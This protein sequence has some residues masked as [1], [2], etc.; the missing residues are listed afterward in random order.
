MRRL[1]LAINKLVKTKEAY[2]DANNALE[3]MLEGLPGVTSVSIYSPN[4]FM[5][6]TEFHS[7]DLYVHSA[8]SGDY[9]IKRVCDINLPEDVT[10]EQVMEMME[11]AK[12]DKAQLVS[13]IELILKAS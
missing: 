4:N 5:L 2:E 1:K 7:I 3:Q 11:T 10:A 13:N 12:N 6:T 8:Q 9:N